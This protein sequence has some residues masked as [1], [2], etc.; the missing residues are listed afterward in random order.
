MRHRTAFTL[1]ELLVVI[2]IIA[3][4]MSILLSTLAGSREAARLVA[5]HNNLRQMNTSFRVYCDTCRSLPY[6]PQVNIWN[7]LQTTLELPSGTWLCPSD[8]SGL[9]FSYSYVGDAYFANATGHWMGPRW[10]YNRLDQH[11]EWITFKEDNPN[12][13]IRW[14]DVDN[15]SAELYTW[16]I[17]WGGVITKSN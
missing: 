16:Q 10:A 13:H 14:Q 2:A 15:L 17:S 5:C 6:S 8:K 1:V 11:P 7:F 3:V 4:L 9:G 12:N